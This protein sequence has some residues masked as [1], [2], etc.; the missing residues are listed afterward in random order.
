MPVEMQTGVEPDISPHLGVVEIDR[1]IGTTADSDLVVMKICRSAQMKICRSA[2]V[3]HWAMS[4]S[5]LAFLASSQS[6]EAG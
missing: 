6:V 3:F 1:P 5:D 4:P 2:Q